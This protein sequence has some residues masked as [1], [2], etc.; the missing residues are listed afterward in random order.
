M[1]SA[2]IKNRLVNKGLKNRLERGG[3]T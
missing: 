1:M 2:N 3:G